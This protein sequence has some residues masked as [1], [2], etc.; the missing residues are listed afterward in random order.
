MSL[1]EILAHFEQLR[2]E[3]G[4]ALQGQAVLASGPPA[5]G[6]GLAGGGG[7][8]VSRG[9]T[10]EEKRHTAVSARLFRS[11]NLV[12]SSRNWDRDRDWGPCK[13]C[14]FLPFFSSKTLTRDK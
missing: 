11:G 1:E 2:Q 9:R 4:R 13:T 3:T 5:E 8:D 7:A 10:R 6:A 12:F 14:S